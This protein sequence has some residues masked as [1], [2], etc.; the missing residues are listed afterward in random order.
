MLICDADHEYLGLDS[1]LFRAQPV[2]QFPMKAAWPDFD[3]FGGIMNWCRVLGFVA[4]L[5]LAAIPSRAQTANFNFVSINIAGA[6]ETQVRGVNKYGEIVGFYRKANSPCP[7]QGPNL[8]VPSCNVVGFKI[9]NGRL[10]KLM[11]PGA[12]STTIMGVND[13]G[14]LVG[15]YLRPEEGCPLGIYHGFVWLR[16]NIVKT[17]DY[18][19][20]AFCGSDSLWTVPMGINFAGTIVGTVWS[21]VDGLPSG[22]FVYRD[23]KFSVMNLGEP[24]FCYG[25][26]GVYGISNNGIIVGSAWRTMGI[27]MWTGY[28]KA[29]ITEDFFV[30]TQDDTFV[31]AVNNRTDIVGWGIPGAGCIAKQIEPNPGKKPGEVIAPEFLWLMYPDSISTFPF[32]IN[33]SRVVVGAYMVEDGSLHGFVAAPGK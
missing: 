25:C 21:P 9:E 6:V 15:F 33:D 5:L 29:G 12:V 31:T 22:G 18:P 19:G 28:L 17:I 14:D 26:S 30:K 23:G 24:G 11:V 20:T 27:P 2:I 10:V 3:F 13:R 32:G 1:Q 8:Q 4:G 16:Q 7:I